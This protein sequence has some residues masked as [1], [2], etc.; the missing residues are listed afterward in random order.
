[1]EDSLIFENRKYYYTIQCLGIDSTITGSPS[2]EIA[3]FVNENLPPM[4][5]DTKLFP[6]EKSIIVQWVEPL[7]EGIGSYK[8]YRSE[9][10]QEPTEIATVKVGISEYIDTNV[11]RGRTYY[12]SIETVNNKGKKSKRPDFTGINFYQ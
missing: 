6:Q 4:V 10:N 12:Y 1:M 2:Q 3:C 5:S 8:I 11:K 7:A 9:K